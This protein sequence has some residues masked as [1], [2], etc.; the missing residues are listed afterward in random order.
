M[1]I[2]TGLPLTP[3]WG[4]GHVRVFGARRQDIDCRTC[5]L[6]EFAATRPMSA[7]AERAP[8]R[9]REGEANAVP[10]SI[11]VAEWRAV[12][13][14]G[15]PYPDAVVLDEA[16]HSFSIEVQRDV[17]QSTNIERE[18]RAHRRAS[19]PRHEVR[20][21]FVVSVGHTVP[22]ILRPAYDAEGRPVREAM[23]GHGVTIAKNGVPLARLVSVSASWCSS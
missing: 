8:W 2:P 14:F 17:P 13:G 4:C 5:W 1:T 23:S 18:I 3:R 21:G 9:G 15:A 20:T 10:F 16:T 22:P 6:E 11:T 7:T 19:A 12:Y